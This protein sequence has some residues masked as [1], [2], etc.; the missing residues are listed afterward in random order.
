MES[1][2][3]EVIDLNLDECKHLMS[4]F[5][6]ITPA[7]ERGYWKLD[8]HLI[9]YTVLYK[10]LNTG[11]SKGGISIVLLVLNRLFKSRKTICLYV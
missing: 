11:L 1:H 10:K 8:S 9:N 3:V 6:K 2:G 7:V 4:E 5:I